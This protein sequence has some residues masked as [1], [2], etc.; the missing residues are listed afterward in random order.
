MITGFGSEQMAALGVGHRLE[1]L[2]YFCCVA[3]GVGAATMVGQ[4][5]GA[6]DVQRARQSAASAARLALAAML[7]FTLLLFALARPLFGLFT[8]DPATLDAGVL[9]LRIQ[10]AVL[11]LMALEETYKGAFT[12]S[13]R[14]LA[15]S[16]IGF[17]FTAAR[18]PAA[19]VLAYPL[20][21]GIAG[22]WLAIAASTAIKGALLWLLWLRRPP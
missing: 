11:A 6:G 16:L 5:L 10:T 15:A 14:T 2:A 13:G 20:G 9:Y 18:I 1:S 7:P 22:V 19:W 17:G 4:H 3:F 8:D 21:L 12:G